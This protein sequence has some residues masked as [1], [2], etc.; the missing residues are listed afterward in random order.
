MT[1]RKQAAVVN[2]NTSV[3]V[4][5]PSTPPLRAAEV[6][7]T[8]MTATTNTASGCKKSSFATTS[9]VG[10]KKHRRQI[11]WKEEFEIIEVENWKEHNIIYDPNFGG[12][13]FCKCTI[14]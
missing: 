1:D 9:S 2:S 7:T 3:T 12:R 11:V 13:V 8:I 5:S 6:T 10:S 4:K 14:F